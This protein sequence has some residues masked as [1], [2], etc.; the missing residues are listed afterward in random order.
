MTNAV[1]GLIILHSDKFRQGIQFSVAGGMGSVTA[2]IDHCFS[3][4]EVPTDVFR[5][6]V[7]IGRK[8]VFTPR[9]F[10]EGA[11]LT[12]GSLRRGSLV[13]IQEGGTHRLQLNAVSGKLEVAFNTRRQGNLPCCKSWS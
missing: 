9:T 10:A 7:D 5:R 8:G 3:L 12:R 2:H 11:R 4:F 1:L 13:L 6:L